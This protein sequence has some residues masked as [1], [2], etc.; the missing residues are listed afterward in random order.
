MSWSNQVSAVIRLEVFKW[1]KQ[2]SSK[3]I[4]GVF[5]VSLALLI[6]VF[7]L[8]ATRLN[9]MAL[10]TRQLMAAS[11]SWTMSMLLP[12]AAVYL[13]ASSF[14]KEF[15]Q[16]TIKNLLLLPITRS[17]L[18]WG[19]VSGVAVAMGAMLLVQFVISG[20]F[21]L[22]V[23]VMSQG[24]TQIA[25][26]NF[27]GGALDAIL[28]F[29][30]AA[31]ILGLIILVSSGVA[32]TLK[33]MGLVLLLSYLGYMGMGL[34]GFWIPR[35]SLISIVSVIGDYSNILRQISISQLFVLIAYYTIGACVGYFLFEKKEAMVCPFE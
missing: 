16:G 22:V 9:L 5:A 12:F 8:G 24:F 33:N 29:G 17:A 2:K 30:G 34:L 26:A 31:A 13:T 7:W 4:L 25:F 20:V 18:Y 10:S 6:A 21:S 32:L 1:T 14:Q 19:K 3:I 15:T 23:A 28:R 11:L 35:F 27:T